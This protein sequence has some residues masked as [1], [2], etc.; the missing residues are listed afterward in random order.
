MYLL[1][2]VILSMILIK[3]ETYSCQKTNTV[4]VASNGVHL[5]LIMNREDLS[6]ELRRGL[7]LPDWVSWVAFGWGDREFY[8]NTPTWDDLKL[9]T[10]FRALFV[11]TESAMHVVWLDRQR[12]NWVAVGLCDSQ[13]NDMITFVQATF[14]EGNEGHLLEIEMAGYTDYDRFYEAHGNFS[15]VQTCNN[16]VN[17]ALKTAH[18]PAAVWSPFDKG[19]LYQLRK[20]PRGDG[21]SKQ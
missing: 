10:A 18:A 12:S 3:P 17:R 21:K 19:V 20:F 16:W 13:L 15:C 2:A 14:A 5:D 11:S 6:E 9:T 8:I 4:F 1:M 7:N